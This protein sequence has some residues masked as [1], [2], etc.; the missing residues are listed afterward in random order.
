[1]AKEV[2]LL[3]KSYEEV[4]YTPAAAGVAGEVLKSNDVLGFL[5]EDITAAQVAAGETRTL[6]TKA[7]TCKVIKNTGEVWAVGEPVYWD[8]TNN[9]FTNVAG[10]LDLAG[11]IKEAQTALVLEGVINFDGYAAFLKA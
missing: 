10:A 4:T 2:E 5:I 3:A 9:W 8:D 11:Y 6:I 1:M 7:E